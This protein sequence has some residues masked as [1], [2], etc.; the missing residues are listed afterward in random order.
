MVDLKLKKSHHKGGPNGNPYA[1]MDNS[2]LAVPGALPSLDSSG[3]AKMGK[4]MQRRISVHYTDGPQ[5]RGL[6]GNGGPIGSNAPA[7]PR[8]LLSQ[9]QE[10]P[11]SSSSQSQ[12]A[13]LYRQP[14]SMLLDE[15][16]EESSNPTSQSVETIAST[17]PQQQSSMAQQRKVSGRPP[18]HTS[19]KHAMIDLHD[20]QVYNLL[21]DPSF[22]AETFI[23]TRLADATASDI[24]KFNSQLAAL[25][26][27]V[28]NDIKN[29]SVQTYERLKSVTNEL[30]TTTA[31]LKFLRNAITELSDITNQMRESAEKRVQLEMDHQSEMTKSSSKR[32][33]EK[34]PTDRSSILVLEK[35]WATEMNSLFKHVEG[36]QK[37]IA[38]IPGRHIIAESGR[39]YE[40]NAATF[41]VLQPAHIFLLNDLILIAT[42][43]RKTQKKQV[44]AKSQVLVADQCWPLREVHVTE[45]NPQMGDKQTFA[46]NITYN[47]LSY[48]YQTDRLDHYRKIMDGYKKARDELRD[49]TEQESIKQKQL[50]DSLNM[51]SLTEKSNGGS[52]SGPATPSRMSFHQNRN[53][54]L[55]LQDLSTR[56]HS[57]SRSTDNSNTLRFLKT[58]DDHVDEIDVL[59]F[60][61]NYDEAL[62]R[63]DDL[64]STLASLKGNCTQEELLLH[65]VVQLKIQAKRD[66]ILKSLIDAMRQKDLP[67]ITIELSVRCLLKLDQQDVAKTMLLNNRSQYITSLVSRVTEEKDLSGNTRLGDYIAAIT[68]V[69][70]Q[71]IKT[72]IE[73][74][75]RL[76]QGHYQSLSYLVDW[77]LEE[78]KEH[79]GSLRRTLH[80]EKLKKQHLDNSILMIHRQVIQLKES[81]LDVEYL[82]D[83]FYRSIEVE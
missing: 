63:L 28:Q 51:L 69:K 30:N 7:L 52:G 76:F 18:V 48:V 13:D 43:K 75:K 55:I 3:K 16:S 42:R 10:R 78:V 35:M 62:D 53:S 66:V 24:E 8:D 26:T 33:K 47:S 15:P 74:Y 21:G 20:P 68:I 73:L 77:A 72:T 44:D 37:Y 41:K 65:N 22:E 79:I 29:S 46:I 58:T 14:T 19:R 27:K 9:Y 40:L 49:I 70:L 32:K 17:P 64:H 59:I 71:N 81:G 6:T 50:R 5:I 25:N 60:H 11:S 31:E 82:F 2:R 80:S 57:R 1:N 38:A 54:Q 12:K 39:W 4:S 36:A 67:L 56:M 45:L 23:S 83:E 34:R 61:E